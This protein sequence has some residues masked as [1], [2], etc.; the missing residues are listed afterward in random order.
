MLFPLK[1]MDA[2]DKKLIAIQKS[3]IARPLTSLISL[4]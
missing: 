3:L 4:P 2:E 1:F